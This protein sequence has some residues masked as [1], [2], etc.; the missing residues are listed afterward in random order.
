VG[1]RQPEPSDDVTADGN[2]ERLQRACRREVFGAGDVKWPKSDIAAKS[3]SAGKTSFSLAIGGIEI[4][5]ARD[6]PAI[7]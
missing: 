7:A 4:G 1:Q 3:K 2:P 5:A 6:L